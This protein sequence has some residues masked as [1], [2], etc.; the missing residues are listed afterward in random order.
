VQTYTVLLPS[1][2]Y[3]DFE[4]GSNGTS[5]T[6]GNSGSTLANAFDS[7]STGSGSLTYTNSPAAAHGSLAAASGT[8]SNSTV[9]MAWS[10]SMPNLRTVFG[11]ANVYLTGSPSAN[12]RFFQTMN[13]GNVVACI[14]ISTSLKLRVFNGG[15]TVFSLST[16]TLPTNQWFRVEWVIYNT[17]ADT[18]STVMIY[19]DITS[20]TPD[21]VNVSGS[22][23]S[24]YDFA[25]TYQFGTLF[26]T[27]S[28][29][30]LYLDDIAITNTGFIG[31]GVVTPGFGAGWYKA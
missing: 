13:G 22:N 19:S 9:N 26:S 11:R 17:T 16:M 24:S 28:T 4:S 2:A 27:S 23:T 30:T 8:S 1:G 5:V 20:S 29:Y 21:E 18:H 10:T 3:N 12:M 31:P 6:T 15:G 14:G 7:I 25:D